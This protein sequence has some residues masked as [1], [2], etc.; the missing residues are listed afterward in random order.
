MF[1]Q[2]SK[3]GSRT[4][5]LLVDMRETGPGQP[6][7][8]PKTSQNKTHHPTEADHATLLGSKI[9]G[10]GE[11]DESTCQTVTNIPGD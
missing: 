8:L 9:G 3:H 1:G 7:S 11:I 6:T 4:T 2:S 10:A 5:Q